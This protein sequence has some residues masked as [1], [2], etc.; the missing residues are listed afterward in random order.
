MFHRRHKYDLIILFSLLGFAISVY[1][2]T[3]HYL[4]IAVPCAIAHGCE[5][6]LSSKYSMLLG[7]PLSVWGI[8]FYVLVIAV[9]LLA[10]HYQSSRLWL[11]VILGVGAGVALVL[12]SLQ[13][14]VIKK[15]C[16]YCFTTDTL[17]ILLFLWDL[18]IEHYRPST[19]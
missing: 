13:F 19:P 17:T 14:F 12:L 1:L 2:A 5:T 9:S 11:T 16:E 10:N 4:Q 3:A 7:L 18:N 15:I 6:V 8:A